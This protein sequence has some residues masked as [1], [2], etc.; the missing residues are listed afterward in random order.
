MGSNTQGANQKV[1]RSVSA[2]EKRLA[3]L[4]SMN[5]AGDIEFY[6]D[7][8]KGFWPFEQYGIEIVKLPG[9]PPEF[10]LIDHETFVGKG[11]YGQIFKAYPIDIKTG[12]V[13]VGSP[14]I[15][16]K[17]E[18]EQ[19]SL[20]KIEAEQQA[21]SKTRTTRHIR[22][23]NYPVKSEKNTVNK[24]CYLFFIEYLPGNIAFDADENL[25]AL[26]QAIKEVGL[27][28]RLTAIIGLLSDILLV[29]SESQAAG[30]VFLHGDVNSKK[31]F[32]SRN[33]SLQRRLEGDGEF[34]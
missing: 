23:E 8:E 7:F 25:L 15:V 11:N 12:Q 32:D 9:E 33:P 27:E 10:Y 26:V 4:K 22:F 31:Y 24:T 13:Q 17:I 34:N 29:Q 18:E 14:F 6:E 20:K 16:K 2:V 5:L 30:P 1:R 28:S 19:T 3:F 21:M